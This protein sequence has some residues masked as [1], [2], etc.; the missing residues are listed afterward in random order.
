MAAID[1]K[2]TLNS[3]EKFLNVFI[4]FF[5]CAFG[6][7]VVFTGRLPTSEGDEGEATTWLYGTRARL[8]GGLIAFVGGLL[9][10]DCGGLFHL[11]VKWG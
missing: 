1:Q 4:A 9:L 11:N 6:I 3:M 10:A 2:Q 8:A 7:F 5:I